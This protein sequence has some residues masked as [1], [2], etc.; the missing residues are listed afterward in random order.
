MTPAEQALARARTW[1]F[2]AEVFLDGWTERARLVASFLPEFHSIPEDADQRDARHHQV[3]GRG[4]PLYESVWRSHEATLGGAVTDQLRTEYAEMGFGLTRTDVE[5]D[6][7]GLQAAAMSFLSGAEADA[8]A[9][10]LDA[11]AL[12]QLQHRLV[13]QHLATW[14]GPLHLATASQGRQELTAVTT[15]L[16]DLVRFHGGR[17]RS[18]T[19]EQLLEDPDTGIKDLVRFLMSPARCGVWF[20]ADDVARI[21]SQTDL[22]CGRSTRTRMMESLWF[23][24]IDHQRVPHLIASLSAHCQRFLPLDDS[25]VKATLD[26]LE[27]VAAETPKP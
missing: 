3:F 1:G 20:S 19:P 23:S 5:P 8:L 22:G 18:G 7:L 26:T 24:S 25:R 12:T 27:R 6:H 10:G 14:V 11:G 17:H 2:L 15:L 9:D 21:A 13:D 4:I 16:V